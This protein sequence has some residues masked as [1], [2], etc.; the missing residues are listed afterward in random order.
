MAKLEIY[1]SSKYRYSEALTAK[2][3]IDEF[4]KNDEYNAEQKNKFH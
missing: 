2:N 4:Y 1:L 3:Y